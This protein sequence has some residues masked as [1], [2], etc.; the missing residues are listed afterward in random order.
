MRRYMKRPTAKAK[1]ID[2]KKDKM[3]IG[4]LALLAG[5]MAMAFFST[6]AHAKVPHSWSSYSVGED[7][8]KLPFQLKS[9]KLGH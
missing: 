5:L 1:A 7:E 8:I 2:L 6:S 4:G 9:Q 3:I